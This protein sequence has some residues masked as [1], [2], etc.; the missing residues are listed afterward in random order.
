MSFIFD[1]EYYDEKTDSTYDVDVLMKNTN[2]KNYGADIDGNRGREA[3]FVEIEEIII[4]LNS[5]RV[6]DRE[7][8]KR[9]EKFFEVKHYTTACDLCADDFHNDHEDDCDDL[10]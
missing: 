4:Y 1:F 3:D 10:N 2:E 5:N 9:V 7:L 6:N 8:E